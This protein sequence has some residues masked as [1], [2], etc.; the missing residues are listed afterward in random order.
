MV[1]LQFSIDI[2]LLAALWPRGVDSASNVN[3]Y[4]EYFLEGK[5]G[6]CVGLTNLP[7]SG[8]DCLEIWEPQPSWNP[9]GLHRPV[10]GLIYLLS[11]LSRHQLLVGGDLF[12][13]GSYAAD[14]KHTTH[15]TV[16]SNRCYPERKISRLP[17]TEGTALQAGKVCGVQS[18]LVSM[19]F[20]IDIV[21][22]A[23]LCPWGQLN[24]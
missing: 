22:P 17:S 1:S 20:F 14:S 5:G 9:L 24:L 3:E 15:K 12:G 10:I 4:Q 23:A 8:S 19:R 11:L 7:P 2:I 21:L 13:V 6:R 16:F 18:P